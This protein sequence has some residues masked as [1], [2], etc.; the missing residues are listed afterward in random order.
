MEKALVY[1]MVIFSIVLSA[2]I[3]KEKLPKY[4]KKNPPGT[5]KFL[6]NFYSDKYEI[7]NL[8]YRNIAI[9]SS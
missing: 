4:L 5:I 3:Q 9:G 2:F 7:S 6:D 8:G 1:F